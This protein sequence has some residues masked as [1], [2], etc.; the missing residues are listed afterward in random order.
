M[1]PG[2]LQS[3]GNCNRN[4]AAIIGRSG[5]EC[6]LNMFASMRRA[7]ERRHAIDVAYAASSGFA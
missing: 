5:C 4:D 1:K 7:D 3:F 6:Q 2:F